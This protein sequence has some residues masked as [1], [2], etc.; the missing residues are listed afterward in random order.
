MASS[1]TSLSVASS[2]S[3][4]PW[5]YEVFLSFRGED[6]RKSFTDHLHEALC[7]Y[8]INT[9]IDDQ[10]RRGEQISSA[11]LQAIE[12][13]RLSIIIFSEHYASS[14]CYGV[15]VTKHEQVYRD[16]M[17]KV[18]KWREALTVASGLSGWDSRD[19]HESEVIK[20]IVSKI[21]NELVDASSSN[22]E[23]LVGMDSRIQDLV[24]LLCIESDD[25]RMVGIWA[26][27]ALNLKVVAFFQM[28]ALHSM[29]VLIVL[30]DVN[31]RQQLEALAGNHN[32]FGRGSRIIITTRERHLLIEKEVDA[33]YEAKELDEDES[34]MLFC[35]HAFKH[36]PPIEDFV[37][38][39]DRALNYTRGIP[40]ALKILGCFLYNRSKKEWESE[41]ERL[42]IIPNKEVQDVLRISFDG[43][44]DNQKD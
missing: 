44:D 13:S 28:L 4:H 14:S 25:V 3:T 11:L 36:K 37:Q 12:E 43:L 20:K 24:S 18:L 8:G 31:H 16:N 7:R 26:K 34:L 15:A 22:M 29:K 2:T 32:W 1:S 42:K 6:T 30:D 38:L 40:L 17:E 5:K 9:F 35:Q 39:C 23:N 19:R 27:F 21:L 41:L 33:T 10:L